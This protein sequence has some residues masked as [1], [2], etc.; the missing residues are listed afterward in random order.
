MNTHMKMAKETITKQL[1]FNKKSK[2]S[3][4]GFFKKFISQ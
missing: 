3:L 4:K 1:F 2:N